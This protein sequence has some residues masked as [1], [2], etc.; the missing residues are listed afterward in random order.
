[1]SRRAGASGVRAGHPRRAA[2]VAL[3]LV[4]VAF[5]SLWYVQRPPR[6]GESYRNRTAQTA[7]TLR[8]QVVTAQLW[9]EQVHDD[10]A[11]TQAADVGIREAEAAAQSATSTQATW[12]LPDGVSPDV[13]VDAVA[14][15]DEVTTLVGDMR[16]AA[17]QARWDEVHELSARAP[18]L[19]RR[20][21]DFE[22][23]VNP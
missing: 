13:R 19:A 3:L 18:S 9:A 4:A 16:L 23:A 21:T 1:M 5:A 22:Q 14:L 7:G 12:D 11:M 17:H 15:G 20:L 2:L 8:S 10:R 6:S